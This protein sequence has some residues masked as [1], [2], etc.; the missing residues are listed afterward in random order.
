M[1]RLVVR[2]ANLL[3]T[4]HYLHEIHFVESHKQPCCSLT[5]L[6]SCDF[7]IFK[8]QIKMCFIIR[9]SVF[10]IETFFA[11]TND[12]N[13]LSFIEFVDINCILVDWLILSVNNFD[14]LF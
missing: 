2:F 4:K 5:R 14:W 11:L 10:S 7:S 8:L 12:Q 9:M 13:F 6:I 3:L 1:L